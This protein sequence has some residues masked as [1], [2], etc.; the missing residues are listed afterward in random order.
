MRFATPNSKL[1]RSLINIRGQYR[2]QYRPHDGAKQNA[3]KWNNHTSMTG[4][5][6]I[7]KA[8]RAAE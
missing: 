2:S 3:K 5:V 7:G 4:H 1:G 6:T 8:K